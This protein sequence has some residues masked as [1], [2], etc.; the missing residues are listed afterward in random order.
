MVDMARKTFA[1]REDLLNR[2][3]ELARE[4]GYTIY[5]MVNEALEFAIRA[6]EG[7][8]SPLK[9]IEALEELRAMKRLGLVPCFERLWHEV[10][11]MAFKRSRQE[12]LR[13]WSEAG[14]WLA[15]LY[16]ASHRDDPL[17][18]LLEDL[19]RFTW[20]AE[21]EVERGEGQVSIRA[22]GPALAEPHATLFATMLESALRALSY[23]ASSKEVGSGFVRLRAVKGR[24]S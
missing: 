3:S 12:V 19:R 14:E 1:A 13:L 16:E 8:S 4:R 21:V 20:R 17:G 11:D 10:V 15:K 9:A 2:I 6:Y 7:G 23:E 24:S 18:R 22:A 5:D